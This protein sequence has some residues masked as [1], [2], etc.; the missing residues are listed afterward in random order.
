ML[1]TM[2]KVTIGCC[3]C[4]FV[5]ASNNLNYELYS[6][7]T[8]IIVKMVAIFILLR[9]SHPQLRQQIRSSLVQK[10]AINSISTNAGI[11]LIAPLGTKISEIK[12]EIQQLSHKKINFELAS[13]KWWLFVAD[14]LWQLALAGWFIV[15]QLWTRNINSRIF[16]LE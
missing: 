8:D 14:S 2:S 15:V 4:R 6:N 12:I 9:Q 16:H 1:Q 7:A 10:M 3:R 13:V 5:V 11:L